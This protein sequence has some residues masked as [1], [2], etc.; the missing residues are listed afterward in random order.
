[1]KKLV[2][3][4]LLAFNLNYAVAQTVEPPSCSIS[5]QV[6]TCPNGSLTAGTG[7]GT[8]TSTSVTTANGVSGSVAT[9]TTTPAITITLGNITPSS[10]STGVITGSTITGSTSISIPSYIS[11][12]TT[13]IISCT[14]AT[15][16]AT[17]TIR[18]GIITEFTGC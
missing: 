11:G 2:L 5:G 3:G 17:V 13:G 18:G 8:V 10:I 14:S 12:A 16:G 15:L 1:M 6:I 4:L 7:S 9:A